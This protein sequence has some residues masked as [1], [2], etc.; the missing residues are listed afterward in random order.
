MSHR[1]PREAGKEIMFAV[2]P[3]PFAVLD[4]EGH[5]ICHAPSARK[6]GL[7]SRRKRE[8]KAMWW[9]A[10]T[11]AGLT[12]GTMVW[13]ADG[14]WIERASGGNRNGLADFGHII[15]D[16]SDGAYCGCNAVPVEGRANREN[17]DTRQA[18]EGW[19]AAQREAYAAAWRVV[20]MRNMTATKRARIAA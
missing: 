12:R 15:A 18:Y 14:R 7:D 13:A 16:S 6:A 19:T 9:E 2:T 17:G 20:A 4:T 11:L 5:A 8:T 10:L 1:I 3:G